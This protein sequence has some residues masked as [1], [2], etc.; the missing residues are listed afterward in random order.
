MA[1]ES[2]RSKQARR[3]RAASSNRRP[4]PGR[5]PE[6]RPAP[7]RPIPQVGKRPTR[8]AFLAVVSLAWVLAGIFVLVSL[9]ASWKLVPGIVFIG[10]GGFYARAAVATLARRSPE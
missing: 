10:I 2:K 8:P 3:R 6:G 9:S 4:A 1:D 5:A 7:D